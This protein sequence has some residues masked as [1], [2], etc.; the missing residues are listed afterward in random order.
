MTQK[1]SISDSGQTARN[2]YQREHYYDNCFLIL[3]SS[4]RQCSSSHCWGTLTW[5]GRRKRQ[6]CQNGTGKVE[7]NFFLNQS[8]TSYLIISTLT[9]ESRNIILKFS[10]KD[11]LL[12][13]FK[14]FLWNSPKEIKCDNF[15]VP[16][17]KKEHWFSFYFCMCVWSIHSS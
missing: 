2:L 16:E 9:T 12:E 4:T 10:W 13:I 15:H 5:T 1:F 11:Y 6:D 17:A 8:F 7:K 14:S 3:A